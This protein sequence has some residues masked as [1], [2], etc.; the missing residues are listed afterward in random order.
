MWKQR[1]IVQVVALVAVLPYIS[2]GT[3]GVEPEIGTSVGTSVVT[4]I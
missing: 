2:A 3:N 4:G 1:S